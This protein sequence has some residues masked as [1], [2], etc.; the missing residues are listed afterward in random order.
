MATH[1]RKVLLIGGGGY[2]GSAIAATLKSLGY[3]VRILDNFIYGHQKLIS[4]LSI[5]TAIAD[6]NVTNTVF[7]NMNNITDVIILGGLVGNQVIQKNPELAE[8]TNYDGVQAIINSLDG[9]GLK[10]VVFISTC[11]NYGIVDYNKYAT[12]EF[13]LNP[14]GEYAKAKVA[15]ERLLLS[16]KDQVD[17][18]GTI[19]RFATAFGVSARTRLDLLVNE[20][21]YN[22]VNDQDISVY[23]ENTWRPYCHVNDFGVLTDKVLRA[24]TKDVYFE[25]FNGGSNSNNYTKKDIL[26]RIYDHNYNFKIIH[27]SENT[28]PRDYKVSFE[29]ARTV[30]KF[31]PKY[32]LSYGIKQLIQFS[33]KYNEFDYRLTNNCLLNSRSMI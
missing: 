10:N 1:D 12:E 32:D 18:T 20:F 22:A 16:K 31:E 4:P 27:N 30:L 9:Y 33:K 25:V 2:V 6:M 8:Q 15:A 11:S 14:L 19:L 23:D 24:S 26:N 21:V 3:G 13:D 5:E 17:Y 7:N 29:K 28:D